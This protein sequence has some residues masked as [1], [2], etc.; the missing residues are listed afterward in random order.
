MSKIRCSETMKRHCDNKTMR[1]LCVDVLQAKIILCALWRRRQKEISFIATDVQHSLGGPYFQTCYRLVTTLRGQDSTRSSK[2]ISCYSTFSIYLFIQ[3]CHKHEQ[4]KNG[5]LN[6]N[7]REDITAGAAVTAKASY[8]GPRFIYLS[9]E[10]DLCL[11]WVC[12]TSRCE[13]AFLTKQRSNQK[14]LS[15]QL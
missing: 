8:N 10:G 14:Q 2:V 15:K 4:E 5:Q 13:A 3:L 7:H 6:K 9:V 11:L 12:F 1:K